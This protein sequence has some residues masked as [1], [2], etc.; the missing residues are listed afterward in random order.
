MHDDFKEIWRYMPEI[1][2]YELECAAMW[3]AEEN[4]Y[5]PVIMIGGKAQVPDDEG[6]LFNTS[7]EAYAAAE[8]ELLRVLKGMRDGD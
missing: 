6:L 7:E 1:L 5:A 8:V 4:K 3:I 2:Q